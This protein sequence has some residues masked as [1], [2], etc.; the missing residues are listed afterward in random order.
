MK[1][2][3]VKLDNLSG[4]MASVYS[5]YLFDEKTTL[6]ER[7]ILEN[8]KNHIEEVT[9]IL[10]KLKVIGTNTGAREQFF[11]LNEGELGDGVCALYDKNNSKLRLYC[12]RFG[13]ALIVIGGGGFKSKKIRA[14]QE[15]KKLTSE[16]YILRSFV[17][18]LKTK[19]SD[20]DIKIN[21]NNDPEE[22]EGDLNF[23]INK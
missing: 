18:E 12:V 8:K 10:N 14:L 16:N 6:L 19:M 13:S 5:L 9:E 3:L 22:F 11:K 17:K 1:C 4:E 7:F 2:R 23:T 21:L 20:K 15:N